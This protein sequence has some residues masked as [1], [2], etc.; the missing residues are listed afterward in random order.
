MRQLPLT[1]VAE[2]LLILLCLIAAFFIEG[3]PA[4]RDEFVSVVFVVPVLIAAYRWPTPAAV[5]TA[6]IAFAVAI[7]AALLSQASTLSLLLHL[8]GFL[9]AST[10]AILLG[11]ERRVVERLAGELQDALHRS[12]VARTTLHII[13]HALPAGVIVSDARG[14][15]TI[16]NTAAETIIGGTITGNAYAPTSEYV[17]ECPDGTPFPP[18]ALPLPRAIERGEATQDVMIRVRRDDGT[19]RV[20]LAAGSPVR[21]ETGHVTA[22]VAVFGDVT[23][24]LRAEEALRASQATLARAQAVAHVG[25]WDRDLRTGYVR[26]SDEARRIFGLAPYALVGTLEEFQKRIHPDDRARVNQ[27]IGETLATGSAYGIDYRIVRPDATIRDVHEEARV[28]RDPSGQPV[29]ILGTVQDITERKRVEVERD[30]LLRQVQVERARLEAILNSSSNAII[31]LDSASGQIQVNPAAE[32]LFGHPFGPEAGQDQYLPQVQRPDGQPIT[33]DELPTRRTLQEQAN[34]QEELVVVQPNGHRVPVLDSSAVVHTKDGQVIGAVALIQDISA[35]KEIERLREEWTTV[36]AHDL[37]QPITVI[38][39]YAMSLTRKE[40]TLL[41]EERNRIAHILTAAENLN[42]LIA[43]LLDLS[44]IEARRLVLQR[45]PID[46]PSLVDAVEERTAVATSDHLFRVTVDGQIPPVLADPA[47]I[48]QVLS[49]LLSNAVKYGDPDREVS[50]D[51]RS[52]GDSARVTVTNVGPGIPADEIA[53]IFTRY[54]RAKPARA[55]RTEGL[56]LGLYI[57]KGIVEAHHGQIS[58]ESI[59]GETTSFSFTLPLVTSPIA[60]SS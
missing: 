40:S 12:E 9:L 42:K 58:V 52:L 19:E 28:E 59:P 16:A 20:I 25:D 2:T 48:E 41:N 60:T 13:I 57:A 33:L 17:L 6:L 46:L 8:A 23:E 11:Y 32:R 45:Q 53:N 31:F 4:L 3:S 18:Q 51:V 30:F 7:V 36:I 35:F 14:A 27:C 34:V 10:L 21:D 56:G 1:L 54:Y 55:G 22:A 15:I 38:I 26:W 50:I 47:R 29:Q 44:R 43:D 24:R 37:R 49:N 39:G 5:L